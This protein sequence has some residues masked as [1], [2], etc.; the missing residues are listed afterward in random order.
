MGWAGLDWGLGW[1]WG[2]AGWAGLGTVLGWGWAGWLAGLGSWAGLVEG[3]LAGAAGGLG[4]AWAGLG[5]GR[6]NWG[7]HGAPT[8]SRLSPGQDSAFKF[9]KKLKFFKF[10]KI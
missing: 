2:G 4:R 10:F 7:L 9:L 8:G 5:L 1:G 6:W 3:A